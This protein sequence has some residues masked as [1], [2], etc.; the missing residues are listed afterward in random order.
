MKLSSIQLRELC[1]VAIH[2]AKQA[3]KLIMES[4]E[5]DIRVDKKESGNSPASEVVTETDRKCQS[6]IISLLQPTIDKYDLAL[7][8]E[9]SED[10]GSRLEKDYFWCIDPIDGTLSYIEKTW[11]YAVSI[12]LIDHSGHPVIGVVFDPVKGTLYHAIDT[13]G[14]FRNEMDWVSSTQEKLTFVID[15]GFENHSHYTSLLKNIETLNKD[16]FSNELRILKNTGAVLN[17]CTVLEN[18]PAI[19]LKL[20]KTKQGGGCFWDFAATACIFNEMNA[21]VSDVKGKKLNLNNAETIYMNKF[22]ILYSSDLETHSYIV[23]V[24]ES[25]P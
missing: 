9:E 12:A 25:L 23:K 22:G 2:A 19:Y 6:L 15:K 16:K 11:G 18:S 24:V 10:N 14:A 7:L 20:P 21:Q 13:L 8:A 17:A 4:H 1:Q 3:G 5:Q